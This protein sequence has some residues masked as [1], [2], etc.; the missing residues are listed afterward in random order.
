[1]LGGMEQTFSKLAG[2]FAPSQPK[3]GLPLTRRLSGAVLGLGIVAVGF[4]PF[5]KLLQSSSFE[6]VATAPMVTLRAPIDGEAEAGPMPLDL[7]ASPASGDILLHIRNHRADR[8]RVDDLARRIEELGDERPGL[9]ARLEAARA[10]LGDLTQQTRLFAE[11]RIL[12]LEARQDELKAEVAAAQA[13]NEE[14]KTTLDRFTALAGRGWTPVAQLNQAQRDGSVAQMLEAGA[15]TRLEAVGVELAAAQRGVFI[16]GGS[17]SNDRPRYMQRADQL[18]QQVS[19]LTET[20]AERDKRERRLTGDLAEEKARHALLAEADVT[21]PVTGRVSEVLIAPGEQVRRGQDMLHLLDCGRVVVTAVISG[22]VYD[23][24]RVG[25][26][27]RFEPR[28]SR[29]QH[30]GR[31]VSLTTASSA[32]ANLGGQASSLA[33]A[34]YRVT[35]SVPK[36]ANEPNCIVGRI[37]RV[38]L[39]DGAVEVT[40]AATPEPGGSHALAFRSARW[41]TS[42]FAMQ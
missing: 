11:A 39:G 6:A 42:R 4:V 8:S 24:L 1:M 23:R 25:S 29:E 2:R 12:Q 26:P 21:A 19:G 34:G 10:Q 37:G 15:L 35:I 27:V 17:G 33:P 31:V 41:W 38:Y 18:E 9:V 32:Q 28:D 20:L 14:A 5:Q 13:R 40:A 30:P 3:S 22:P 36:L 16:G 7:G